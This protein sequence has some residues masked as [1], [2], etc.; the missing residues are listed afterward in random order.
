M[1]S[2]RDLLFF[3]ERK[4]ERKRKKK[5][6]YFA[7]NVYS[8]RELQQW[9]AVLNAVH[10]KNGRKAKWLCLFIL[11]FLLP[12]ENVHCKSVFFVLELH[13][14]LKRRKFTA[15]ALFIHTQTRD[16]LNRFNF[17]LQQKHLRSPDVKIFF[18]FLSQ[19]TMEQIVSTYKRHSDENWWI[20][21]SF[22]LS[23]AFHALLDLL[24]L[25][26]YAIEALTFV[27]IDN[28]FFF[29]FFSREITW[30]ESFFFFF[31]NFQT[32]I[33]ASLSTPSDHNFSSEHAIPIKYISFEELYFFHIGGKTVLKT[34]FF[35]LL[36]QPF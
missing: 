23:N 18:L 32:I 34:S 30:F 35:F 4:R 27:S 7:Q 8:V 9:I 31:S 28:N 20:Y 6:K 2:G 10:T 5:N 19:L 16:E 24:L 29:K 1:P 22:L 15:F 36:W 26:L 3:G 25:E 13:P 12:R 17:K 11:L 33:F 14:N 21:E